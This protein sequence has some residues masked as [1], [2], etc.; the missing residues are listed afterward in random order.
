MAPISAAVT[1]LALLTVTMAAPN[2]VSDEFQSPQDEVSSLIKLE[3]NFLKN[4][5][6]NGSEVSGEFAHFEFFN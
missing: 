4:K 1:L 3:A 6:E 5:T 2:G